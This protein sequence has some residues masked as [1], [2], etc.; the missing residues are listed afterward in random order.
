[1]A[2]LPDIALLTR[3]EA[4]EAINDPVS[5]SAVAADRD[6]EMF[7][8]VAAVSRRID[9]LCGPVV[10]RQVVERHHGGSDVLRLRT[11]PVLSVTEVTVDGGVVDPSVYDLDDD[12][13]FVPKLEHVTVWPSGRR[14]VTVTFQAGRAADTDSVDSLFKLAAANVLN[15][16]WAKYGG[17]WASGSDPFA[18]AGAGP[19][20]FDEL[21]HNV[22]RWLADEMLPP[23]VA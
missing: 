18:E 15:G 21:T 22:K 7:L 13:R 5:G 16:L 2:T 9:E 3:T 17:A 8:W 4:Y 6:S 12:N 14:N 19:Q 10:A 23:T 20:F 11:L 1:M